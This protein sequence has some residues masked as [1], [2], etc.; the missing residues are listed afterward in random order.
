MPP[1]TSSASTEAMF[2]RRRSGASRADPPDRYRPVRCGR[3]DGRSRKLRSNHVGPTA[4]AARLHR[5]LLRRVDL[6]V[7]AGAHPGPGPRRLRLRDPGRR[8][9]VGRPHVRARPRIP[10]GAPRDPDD[11]AAQRAQPGLRRQPEDRLHVR[12]RARVRRRRPAARRRPVRARGDA[13]AARPAARRR[14][15]GVRQPDDDAVRRAARGDAALQ[16][17]RQPGPHGDAERAAADPAQRVP[18]RLPRL[19]GAGAAPDP[20]R[21]QLRRLPLRHRDHHP[22]AQRAS[23]GSP[24]CRSRRTTATRSA[25]S[26]ASGTPRTSR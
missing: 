26:T 13:A 14:G 25:T 6:D 5:R 22:A 11:G 9:R 8:R 21:A 19:L 18:Q 10:A 4:S 16:V 15:R 1:S 24:R 17:R 20:L 23:S 7:R 3:R 12:D 2:R